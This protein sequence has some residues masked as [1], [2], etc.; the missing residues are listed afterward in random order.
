MNKKLDN[1]SSHS[2]RVTRFVA[3]VEAETLARNSILLRLVATSTKLSRL[4]ILARR[5]IVIDRAISRSYGRNGGQEEEMS[6]E[7]DGG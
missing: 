5:Y 7:I 6:R 1:F 3:G 4:S 2:M